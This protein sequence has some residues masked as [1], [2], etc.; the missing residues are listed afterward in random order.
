MTERVWFA[1]PNGDWWGGKDAD[2]VFVLKESDLPEGTD[3]ESI[4]GDKFEDLITQHG[5]VSYID[6]DERVA[7]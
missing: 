7:R 5:T 1:S 4:E 6:S 2:F 3:P